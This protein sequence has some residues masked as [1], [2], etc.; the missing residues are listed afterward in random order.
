[1]ESFFQLAQLHDPIWQAHYAST[2][3]VDGASVW[4]DSCTFEFGGRNGIHWS[5]FKSALT[6]EFTPQ[7]YEYHARFML[8]QCTMR[9]D[10]RAYIKQFR[11]RLNRC[12]DVGEAEALFRFVKGL[13]PEI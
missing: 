11:Q 5:R 9:T 13:A 4:L 3:L 8:D 1:M 12:S 7:D 10:V 2:R 6:A